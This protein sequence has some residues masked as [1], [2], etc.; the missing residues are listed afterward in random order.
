MKTPL[1]AIA[2]VA[3]LP[4]AAC[5][6]SQADSSAREWQRQECNKVVDREDRER[7]LKRADNEFG[8]RSSEREAEKPARR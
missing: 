3:L 4:L 5:T 8:T 1:A 7:C 2:L 6:P